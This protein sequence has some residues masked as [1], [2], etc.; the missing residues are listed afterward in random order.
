MAVTIQDIA[1]HLNLATSTVSKAL[2]NYPDVSQQTKARVIEVARE[3][4]YY[5][6]A[7]ARNLRRRRTDKIG[8]LFSFPITAISEYVSKLITGAII[9]AE[10]EG[11]NL[12]LYP[13]LEDQL[14]NLTRICRAREIDG[15]LVLNRAGI[16][17]ILAV[18]EQEAIPFVLVDRRAE[19]PDI[20]FVSSDHYS[21]ALLVMRHLVGLGHRRIGYTSRPLL[22]VTNRDRLVGY[23][24]VLKEANLPFDENLVVPTD[25]DLRS[26]YH[27]MNNLLDLP[28]PPTAVFAVHDLIAIEC[29]RAATDRGLRVPEDVAIVGFDNWHFSESTQPPL[30]SVRIPLTEIGRLATE[31]VLTCIGDNNSSPVRLILPVEL[32]V[33]QSTAGE[34][35]ETAIADIAD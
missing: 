26:G 30:S 1:Q 17:Q 20:S 8:F 25:T 15:L 24:E 22:G 14:E 29:L 28:D 33:R 3:L 35:V 10:K 4:G 2:N 16:D 12:I 6:S 32:V 13:L 7:P 9:A 27:A 21:G 34:G 18:L 31:T 5:P 11:Y 23:K 19:Q